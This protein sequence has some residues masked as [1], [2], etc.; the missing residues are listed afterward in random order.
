MLEGF[1]FTKADL[2][3]AIKNNFIPDAF[4]ILKVN[5]DIAAKRAFALRRKQ[6]DLQKQVN[7]AKFH[8]FNGQEEKTGRSA[9]SGQENDSTNKKNTNDNK[10]EAD[11]KIESSNPNLTDEEIF[12]DLLFM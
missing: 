8:D 10:D 2:K 1:P 3:I 6:L 5:S 4:V 7:E 12:E 11:I 9:I